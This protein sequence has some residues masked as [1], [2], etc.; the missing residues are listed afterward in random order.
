MAQGF[1]DIR[2]EMRWFATLVLTTQL[3]VIGLLLRAQHLL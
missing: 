3:A 2:Q 1:R